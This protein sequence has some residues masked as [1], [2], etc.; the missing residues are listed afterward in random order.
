MVP[1]VKWLGGQGDERRQP[2]L[3]GKQSRRYKFFS[4]AG[5]GV[6]F[7]APSTEKPLPQDAKLSSLAPEPSEQL[8]IMTST[9]ETRQIALSAL[10][11]R[12]GPTGISQVRARGFVFGLS[13]GPQGCPLLGSQTSFRPPEFYTHAPVLSAVPGTRSALNLPAP[14]E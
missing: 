12:F 5:G 9:S 4:V 13:P 7:P 14:T 1:T 10:A 3:G 8:S 11:A 6:F 2:R